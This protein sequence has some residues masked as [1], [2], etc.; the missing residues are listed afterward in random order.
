MRVASRVAALGDRHPDQPAAV[1]AGPRHVHGRLE[2]RHQPLVGVDGLVRHR[3]DLGGVVQQ[4]GHERLGEVGEVVVVLAVEEGVVVAAEDRQ[5]G[6]HAR[7]LHPLH[8]LGHERGVQAVRGGHL[9]DDEPERHHAVGHREGV[10]VAEVDLLLAR[11]V[12]VEAVLDGDPHRLQRADGLL[13]QRPRDVVRREVEEAALVERLRRWPG[14]AAARSRRTRCPGRR[15]TRG[16]G[17]AGRARG[18]A[19]PGGGRRRTACRRGCGCRRTPGPR[20]PW[21]RPTAA[22]RTCRGRG[23]PGRRTP[24]SARSPRSTS[25]RTSSRPRARS[26][27]R[28][29]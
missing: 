27:A 11:G 8:R 15:R 7:A 25:R 17:R 1:V 22:A 6:V 20:G 18:A 26:P 24:G 12:L 16:P 28:P 10:G 29:G 23:S 14:L 19:A 5:V 3:R 2:A 4:T 21:C 13:P 9:A